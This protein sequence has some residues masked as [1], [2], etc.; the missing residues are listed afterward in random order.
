MDWLISAGGA[1][2]V[3][4]VL[5]D[6][7]HTLWHPKGRGTLSRLVMTVVWRLSQRLH[8]RG[9]V[10][11]L[12]GPLA[13]VAVVATWALMIVLG[14]A[15]IYLPQMPDGFV[16]ASGLQP[17]RRVDFLDALYLS[18]VTVATLGFGDIV[19]VKSWLR[20]AA[21]LQALMG[22]ALLTASVSWVLEVYPALT[23]RRGLAVRLA[24]LRRAGTA[25]R[26]AGLDSAAA[27]QLLES[28]AA[29][30]ALIR[31]DLTQYTET[32]YFHD[33]DDHSSLA[34]VIS[35]AAEL[36]EGGHASPRSDV[37]LAAAVL[38]CALDDLARLLDEHF[39]HVG[40]TTSEILEAYTADH[41]HSLAHS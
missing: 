19:P 31:V 23:R 33:G 11:P 1:G 35:Y 40:G 16:F 25:G 26:V 29:E 3:I 27:A 7:F 30:I 17:T 28:L 37:Q 14:W 6:I 39:L 15:L 9:Q 24:L 21:P 34:A 20:L 12:A 41:G 4:I 32:Y 2:A 10:A 18:L 36:A 5:R 13:M 22:F 38:D 8:P